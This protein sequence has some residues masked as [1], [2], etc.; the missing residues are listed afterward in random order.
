MAVY[1]PFSPQDQAIFTVVSAGPL[2]KICIKIQ[3]ITGCFG[4]MYSMIAAGG[5]K[6]LSH[7]DILS[8]VDC[9]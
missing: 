1:I 9:A 3:Y 5:W 7:G 2:L 8:P 4:K 6:C